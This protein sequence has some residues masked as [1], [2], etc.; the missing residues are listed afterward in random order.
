MPTIAGALDPDGRAI[1]DV[2]VAVPAARTAALRAAGQAVPGPLRLSAM[3]DPGAS[4][5]CLDTGTC[6][7]LGLV[8]AGRIRVRTPTSGAQP[9]RSRLYGLD[10]VIPHPTGNPVH[11][12]ALAALLAAQTD[13]SPFRI[14]VLIGRDVL[15]YCRFVYDGQGRKFELHY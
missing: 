5:T 11:N 1:V 13:L 7:A 9:P 6:R 15:T 3:L 4:I 10:L 2:L 12:F 8:P 14:G